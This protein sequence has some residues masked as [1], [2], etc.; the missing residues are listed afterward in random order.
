[1]GYWATFFT[2][3]IG[4]LVLALGWTF[5][6]EWMGFFGRKEESVV[7]GWGLFAAFLLGSWL[8]KKGL[9]RLASKRNGS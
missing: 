3:L 9:D 5:V 8:A 1:M 7:Y 6:G 4:G 2:R